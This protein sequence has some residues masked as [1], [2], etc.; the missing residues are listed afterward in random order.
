M[1]TQRHAALRQGPQVVSRKS[2]IVH[3]FRRVVAVRA[4][5][6]DKAASYAGVGAK[7]KAEREL[8]A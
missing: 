2:T 6:E 3:P 4:N 5:K 7:Q 8:G 1:L